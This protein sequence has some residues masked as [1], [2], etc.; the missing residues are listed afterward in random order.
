MQRIPSIER[1]QLGPE[2]QAAYDRIAASRGSVRGPFG[3]LLHHPLLG[4]RVA[5]VGEQVRYHGVLP[6]SVRELAI[7]T[8]AREYNA[9]VEWAAHAPLARKEGASAEALE[10]VRQH[11]P[12]VQSAAC[13]KR[14][15]STAV[16]TLFSEHALTDD[17][18][19]QSR[20]G[21]WSAGRDR[22]DR[23]R[24]CI[25]VCSGSCSTPCECQRRTGWSPSHRKL[26]YACSMATS[27]REMLVYVGCYTTSDRS[28]R[29][30]GIAA[31]RMDTDSGDWQ[32]L[33][34]VARVANPS[35]LKL[36]PNG[37]PAVLR[38]R[39][40]LQRGQ[41]LRDRSPR[42][43]APPR[44]VAVR[45]LESGP[46]GLHAER[47]LDGGGQL[48]R[49][50]HCRPAGPRRRTTGQHRRPGQA[51]WSGWDQIPCNKVLRIP[52]ISRSIRVDRL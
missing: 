51:D 24:R 30:E 4:E 3:V 27:T 26:D 38:P 29:G 52:T 48:H 7:C 14:S 28:G 19:A 1:E 21:L 40:G 34:T 8:T 6:G 12:T 25:T 37:N 18:Y 42:P 23:A 45:R 10:V 31:F 43:P 41:W 9:A 5:D 35:Y 11:A 2:G 33:G 39:R 49:C 32:P 20:S 47:A 50:D 22:V 16:R 44:N 17:Q 36:H 15:S 13:R 46:P